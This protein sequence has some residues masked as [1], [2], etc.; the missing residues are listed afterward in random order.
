MTVNVSAKSHA[1]PFENSFLIENKD[2]YAYTLV[3]PRSDHI[4]KKN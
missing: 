4:E 2:V 1:T 3:I